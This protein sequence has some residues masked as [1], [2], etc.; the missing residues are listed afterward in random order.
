MATET[1]GSSSQL[2][3]RQYPFVQ[4]TQPLFEISDTDRPAVGD[5]KRPARWLPVQFM[6]LELK[7]W[8]V[9]KKGTILSICWQ[10]GTA[11]RYIPCNGTTGNITDTYTVDDLVAG[12]KDQNGALV[13][14]ASSTCIRYAGLWPVGVAPKVMYQDIK[15]RYLNYQLESNAQ[16]L[17]CERVVEVAYFTYVDTGATSAAQAVTLMAQKTQAVAYGNLDTANNYVAGRDYPGAYDGDFNAGDYVKPDQNGNYVKWTTGD[18]GRLKV[19]QVLSVDRN[20]PKDN[21]E[22]VQ[23]YP[24]SEMPG[25]ET[26]GYPGHLA[27]VA[28]SKALR[29]R[30]TF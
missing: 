23:T 24:M 22:L 12:V 27:F 10:D 28:A 18:D 1:I 14:P 20:F 11:E 29:V 7:D 21:L 19:G 2:P 3:V 8:V 5:A 9:I 26:A 13:V 30:L 25:S 15:D 17:L 6:D 4:R 16:P